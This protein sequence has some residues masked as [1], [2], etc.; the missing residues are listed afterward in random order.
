MAPPSE[1][2]PTMQ[3]V[4]ARAQ[5]SRMT[6]SYALRHD[7]RIP[8][9]T[10]ERVCQ[11]AEELGYRVNPLV[12]ALMS[13][14]KG[15]FSDKGLSTLAVLLRHESINPESEEVVLP[16]ARQRAL[17]RGYQ[18][19][20]FRIALDGQNGRQLTRVLRA[21]GIRGII[22]PRL[23][24]SMT[25]DLDW[26]HFSIVSQGYTLMEPELHRVASDLYRGGLLAVDSLRELGYR[27]IG[28][29]IPKVPSRHTHD[30]WL[31]AFL[32]R[33]SEWA[34]VEKVPPLLFSQEAWREEVQNWAKKNRPDVI[35]H[36]HEDLFTLFTE[37][38]VK[39]PEDLGLAHLDLCAPGASHP[40][41]MAGI[42][43]RLADMGAALVDVTVARLHANDRG[44]PAV[45]RTM[46]IEGVWMPGNLIRRPTTI[47]VS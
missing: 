1:S 19:E 9:D 12:A 35:L 15:G 4:A 28:L 13:E 20:Y 18:L 45:P 10:R 37:S 7:P 25:L 42:D 47:A 38:G 23:G 46:L 36:S 27:R 33:Q 24:R 31:A 26:Q 8:A 32:V 14:R 39:I 2:K 44:I 16:G 5:L 6:V 43:Q 17:E 30:L 29:A 41:G 21:R 3:D 11:A 22:I 40:P 34:S